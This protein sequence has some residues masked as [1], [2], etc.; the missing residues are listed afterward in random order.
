MNLARSLAH[1]W[2]HP[3]FRKLVAVRI[4][5]QTSDGILQVGMAAY[6]LLTPNTAPDAWAVAAVLAVTLLPYSVIGPFVSLTLDRFDRRNVAVATDAVRVVLALGLGALVLNPGLREHWTY[7]LFF[8]LVLVAMSLNRY[9]LAGLQ[10][11][12]PHTVDTDEYLSASSIMPMI[13]PFGVL[14]G[15][16]VA[17]AL[18][19][20][21][22]Q[23]LQTYQADALIFLTAAIGFAITVL[24]SLRIRSGELGPDL[25]STEVR[26]TRTI[27]VARGLWHA[28]LHLTERKPAGLSIIAI[29]L[30]KTLVGMVQVAT[31]LL[32]RNYFHPVADIDAATA[33]L[34]IWAAFTGAGYLISAPLIPLLANRIGV[35]RTIVVALGAGAV[36]VVVPGA[37]FEPWALYVTGL[38]IGM[39]AQAC[40]ICVDNVVQA[41]VDD[42]F[43]GRVFT[44]YDMIFN[45]AMPL[46]AVI[47]ALLFPVD[48]HS[49]PGFVGMGI[50]F[51]LIGLWFSWA[52]RRISAG[53]FQAGAENAP[54]GITDRDT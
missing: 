32:F 9:L 54:A 15:G 20:G 11:A 37:L 43:K 36:F 27:D 34:A 16:G 41:H 10:A 24:L 49:L 26:T 25:T 33:D 5:T 23:Q 18:R 45:A 48:A 30:Q 53:T 22:S 38:L 8:G 47:V 6:V 46:A 44:I 19:L 21:L 14:V 1:L 28:L 13:G 3:L 39:C 51:A 50:A 2:R 42:D 40:K 12:V 4:A 35:R 29:G 31:I 7:W 17:F 52:G